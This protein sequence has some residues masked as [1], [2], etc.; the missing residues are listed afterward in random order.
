MAEEEKFDGLFMNAIQHSRGIE[1][2]FD[3][4]FSFMRRRTDFFTAEESSAKVV[5]D[6][7]QKHMLLFREDKKK[8][9]L[10]QQKKAAETK[11]AQPAQSSGATV[12]EVDEDE[13]MRIELEN[14]RK[15]Q[16]EAAAK[17][18]AAKEKG[19]VEEEAKDEKDEKDEKA[20]AASL[21]QKPNVGN[22]G[23]TEQYVWHQT[24]DEVT[25]YIKL[26]A[27]TAAKQL[28][29]SITPSKLSVAFKSKPAEPLVAGEW[30]GRVNASES[31]WNIERDGE[32]AT[33]T[34]TLEKVDGKR[35]WSSL[36]TG[37]V[38]IDTQKV[39]P[40]NSKLSDLDGDTRATVEKMKYDQ[41]QK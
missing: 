29:V 1:P 28:A 21:K 30:A 17:E 13:A 41:Q 14:L 4:M 35:W 18:A 39:E 22:G 12:E 25:A 40:E 26:P 31:F 7:M 33:L 27:G 36:L 6:K 15:R 32:K 23:Y 11:S 34:M 5:N 16:A 10:L 19:A 20:D 2:F 3:A 38:E 8:E 9:Q 37:D 24:L